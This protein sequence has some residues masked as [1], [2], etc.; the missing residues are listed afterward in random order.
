[1]RKAITYLFLLVSLTSSVLSFAQINPA[2]QWSWVKGGPGNTTASY[3]IKGEAAIPNTPGIRSQSAT[4]TD[5]EGK[6]YLYGGG[7]LDAYGNNGA[8]SDLWKF[9][10]VTN[11]WTWINGSNAV[12]MPPVY[13]TK[14]VF[15]NTAS[16]G[17]RSFAQTWQGSDGSFWLYGGS[18]TN[19]SGIVYR[20]DLWQYK[21]LTNQWAWMAGSNTVNQQP[22]YTAIGS[23]S[24]SNYPGS[25]EGTANWTDLNGNLWM[26]GGYNGMGSALNDLWMYNTTTGFWTAVQPITTGYATTK[27]APRYHSQRWTDGEGNLWLFGGYG[28]TAQGNGSFYDLWKFTITTNQWTLIKGD[29]TL[30]AAPQYGTLGVASN[31]NTPGGRHFAES[32]KDSDGKFWLFGGSRAG[33]SYVDIPHNDLWSYDPVTNQWTWAKG[34][35]TAYANNVY[36]TKGIA[37]PENKPG[38]R[39]DLASWIDIS[40]SLWL[41]GGYDSYNRLNDL[42]KLG[43]TTPQQSTR[44]LKVNIYGGTNPYNNAQ[45]N[46]WNVTASLNSGALTYADNAGTSSVIATLSKNNSVSDNGSSYG[47]GMAPAEVLRYTSTSSAVRTLTFSGLDA[48]KKYNLELYASRNSNSG[49]STLFTINGAAQSIGTYKNLTN[50]SLFSNLSANTENKIVV[51]IQNL[52]AYS[53]LN[54]F[55]LTEITNSTDSNIAPTVTAGADQ[56]ISLPANNVTLNGTAS[57]ADG[58]IAKYTWSKISGPTQ[59][60]FS[61]RIVPNPTVS[62]LVQGT[63]VFRLTATDNE[64]ATSFDDVQITVAATLPPAGTKY[65]KVNIFGGVNPY[66]NAEWNNWNVS[67]ALTSSAFKYGDSSS[68]AVSA[69]LSKSSG[70]NDNGSAYGS[71]MAPA[72]VLRYASSANSV[73]MLTLKGLSASKSYSLEVYASRNNTGN[74]TIFSMNDV[75]VTIKTD[76]NLTTKVL[77]SNLTANAQGEL[78]LNIKNV[79]GWNYINGFILTEKQI[80]T[81]ANQLPVV[82]AGANKT[83]S[84][85]VNSTTLSGTATDND[86]TI[87]NYSWTKVAGPAQFTINNSSAATT[88][89]S[90]LVQGIYTFRLTVTDNSGAIASDDV[91]VVVNEA[92]T[93]KSIKVNLFGGKNPYNNA[94]WNNW[95]VVSSLAS[96]NLK[97]PDASVSTISAAISQSNGILDNG[98]TYGG[99][100]APPEVLRYTSSSSVTRTLTLNGLDPSKTYSLELY[101]SRNNTGNSTQFGAGNSSITVLTD[102]NKT[103]QAIFSNLTPTTGGKLIITINNINSF[104]YLN[105]F[106]LTESSNTTQTNATMTGI[107]KEGST[108]FSVKTTV[109]KSGITVYPNPSSQH[110]NVL[111]NSDSNQPVNIRTYDAMG[112]LIEAI[113]TNALN[114]VVSFGNTYKPGV[115]FII[116]TFGTEQK[117]IQVIKQ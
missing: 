1:M 46:N 97:Y 98:A 51:S 56:T 5:L 49:H 105:G 34:D 74:S 92:A 25:R 103:I 27:P 101:A 93:T 109:G 83:I 117:T 40:G 48:A 7:G 91:Q 41:F 58:S 20:S 57:D 78:I 62:N 26:F 69:T 31:E 61:S 53:Y 60:T 108:E 102:K 9:D 19:G 14:G 94:E 24:A 85:P 55:V 18:G 23:A 33:G 67:S 88:I 86:G 52:N 38:A 87:A 84:L 75:S 96:G 17:S 28:T 64:G 111:I 39:Y 81:V 4:W 43:T 114:K 8:L 42:W 54:G 113:R 72:E 13:E 68:S 3:G 112:K 66:N 29:G 22:Y 65:V 16:P 110:F 95:N 104:N 36:G 37:A 35:N 89:V 45:W 71:G 21:P 116:A 63:Y 47:S 99:T 44:S 73:R 2:S 12:N 32:W 90:G 59:F 82:N 107:E 70:I 80:D 100:M 106:I 30:S 50:K 76:K 6:F 77:F 10:P 115:Y 11:A 79:N 15:S